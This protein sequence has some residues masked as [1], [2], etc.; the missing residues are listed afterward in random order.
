M[1]I[2]SARI[3][4]RFCGWSCFPRQLHV[5]VLNFHVA[6]Y[7]VMEIRSSWRRSSWNF[8]ENCWNESF[9]FGNFTSIH[10]CPSI[11]EPTGRDERVFILMNEPNLWGEANEK[12]RV[13]WVIYMRKNKKE[14]FFTRVIM[15]FKT[16]QFMLKNDSNKCFEDVHHPANLV[17]LKLFSSWDVPRH[18][19]KWIFMLNEEEVNFHLKLRLKL[20]QGNSTTFIISFEKLFLARKFA[21]FVHENKEKQPKRYERKKFV[22]CRLRLRKVINR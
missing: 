21:H 7:P 11:L 3:C 1:E 20:Q 13:Q 9:P 17:E 22:Y 15:N 12:T 16:F 10:K 19:C 18:Y 5:L 6:K 4:L 14:F 8:Q 2:A